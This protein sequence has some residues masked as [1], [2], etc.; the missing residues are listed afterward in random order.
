MIFTGIPFRL[1]HLIVLV[2]YISLVAHLTAK[3]TIC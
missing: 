2:L 3:L 1:D